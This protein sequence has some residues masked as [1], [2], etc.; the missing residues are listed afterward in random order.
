MANACMLAKQRIVSTED[1]GTVKHNGV[2]HRH[3][4]KGFFPPLPPRLR[5]LIGQADSVVQHMPFQ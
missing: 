3:S 4:H 5:L 1:Q 2:P